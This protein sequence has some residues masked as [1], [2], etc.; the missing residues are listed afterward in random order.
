MDGLADVA[1]FMRAW[2]EISTV[3]TASQKHMVALFMRAWI[4]I[5]TNVIC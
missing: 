4:E 2:I 5:S 3:P 1:L